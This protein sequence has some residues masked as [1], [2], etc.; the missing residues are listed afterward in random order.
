MPDFE[1]P[2][3]P[4]LIS[5]KIRVTETQTVWKFQDFAIT[6]ILREINLWD[7]RSAKT[8]IFAILEALNFVNLVNISLQ[9]VEQFIKIKIQSL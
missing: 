5:R 6:H 9:N 2:Q 4:Q 1:L 7:S 8:A 3:S